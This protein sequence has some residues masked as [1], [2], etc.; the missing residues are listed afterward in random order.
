MEK[1]TIIVPVLNEEGNL[2]LLFQKLNNLKYKLKS[3]VFIDFIFVNDG[4]VDK[5]ESIL[6][7]LAE[8]FNYFKFI[9]FTRNFG[10]QQSISAGINFSDSDYV[11]TID[12]DLQDPPELIEDMYYL[13][14]TGY[15]VVYAQRESR[16]GESFFKIFTAKIFYKFINFICDLN[17][18]KDTGDYRLITK[19]VVIEFKKFKEKHK[20]IR[21]LIPWL[22]FKST[23]ILFKRQKRYSGVTNYNFT[24]MMSFAIDASLSFSTRPL[25]YLSNLGIFFIILSITYASFILYKKIF[26]DQIIPGFTTILLF[27]IFFGGLNLFFLG[28]LGQYISKIFEQSKNRPEY[29][30]KEL[31]NFSTDIKSSI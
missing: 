3:E 7:E 5:T 22:G 4:S 18:P 12:A 16:E 24:K 19:K 28:I 14:K 29:I 30:I 23:S 26:L 15:D 25:I 31:K 1:I 6:A 17:I 11:V 21:G 27:I 20:F 8:K 10:H 2:E 9:S 13:S